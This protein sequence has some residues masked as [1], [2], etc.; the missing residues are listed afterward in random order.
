MEAK[1]ISFSFG[2]NWSDFV[3]HHVTPERIAIAKQ[4]IADFLEMP[5]LKGKTFLDVGCGSGLSSLAAYELEADRIV[6]FDVDPDSV[7][8]TNILRESA[9]TPANWAVL[10]GSVLDKAFVGSLDKADIV[11]SWGVLHHTGSMWEAVANT[12]RLMADD[13]L[14]YLALYTTTRKSQ[15]WIRVKHAYNNASRFGKRLMELRYLIRYTLIPKL[16]QG[17]NPIRYMRE[18]QASRGMAYL[19]DVRDWLGGYPYE[20]AKIEEVL[21]FA[22]KQLQLELINLATG[23]A[24]TEYL[25]SRRT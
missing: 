19:I 9:G 3:A 24:N 11:Y 25:F 15:Y 18:Y 10:E 17:K 16:L 22:R 2:K 12:A 6:S 1:T 4:H 14:F 21:R 20:D 8:A 23:E 13:G 7:R 5:D